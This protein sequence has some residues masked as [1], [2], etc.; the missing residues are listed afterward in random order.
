[1]GK[2]PLNTH[3]GLTHPGHISLGRIQFLFSPSHFTNIAVTSIPLKSL[4]AFP[5][6]FLRLCRVSTLERQK[7]AE[8]EQRQWKGGCSGA[9]QGCEPSVGCDAELCCLQSESVETLGTDYI[10]QMFPPRM[11]ALRL[12]VQRQVI[13]R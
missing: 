1:M 2:S 8:R 6:P 12:P 13:F 3:R 7:S 5:L 10:L 9:V 11:K 4:G